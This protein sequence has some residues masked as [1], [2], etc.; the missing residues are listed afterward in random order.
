MDEHMKRYYRYGKWERNKQMR[1]TDELC[2]DMGSGWKPWQRTVTE[3]RMNDTWPYNMVHYAVGGVMDIE[4]ATDEE[5]ARDR[6]RAAFGP[7]EEHP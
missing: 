5:V 6:L 4:Y 3:V 2:A 7:P 1:I